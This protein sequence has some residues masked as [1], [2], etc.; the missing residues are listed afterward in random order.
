MAP[1]SRNVQLIVSAVC[2]TICAVV[3]ARHSYTA[4]L[5]SAFVVDLGPLIA[6]AEARRKSLAVLVAASV[7]LIALALFVERLAMELWA[8]PT[9]VVFPIHFGITTIGLLMTGAVLLLLFHSDSL[10]FLDPVRSADPDQGSTPVLAL[11]LTAGPNRSR[12]STGRSG[13][14]TG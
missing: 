8:F 12:H 4:M 6:I 2:C 13:R 9:E 10:R 7:V 5:P 11:A 3:S 1:P 14:S